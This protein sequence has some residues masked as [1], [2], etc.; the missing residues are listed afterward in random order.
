MRKVQGDLRKLG[1]LSRISSFQF[2]AHLCHLISNPLISLERILVSDARD[3]LSLHSHD[4]SL[5]PLIPYLQAFLASAVPRTPVQSPPRLCHTL[6]SVPRHYALLHSL[7][8]VY[9]LE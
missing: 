6:L 5:G 9:E 8:Q 1:G 4:N 3:H 2:C 7:A